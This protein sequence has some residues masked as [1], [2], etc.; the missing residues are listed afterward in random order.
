MKTMNPAGVPSDEVLSAYNATSVR[1]KPDLLT[2]PVSY[3]ESNSCD[4]CKISAGEHPVNQCKS[5]LQKP[6]AGNPGDSITEHNGP[7]RKQTRK[8]RYQCDLCVYNTTRSSNLKVH[9]LIH[10]GE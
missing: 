2:E 3:E 8:K 6:F 7:K 9:K 1:C 10:T 5:S 4:V